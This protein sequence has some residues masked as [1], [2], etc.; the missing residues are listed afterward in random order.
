[1]EDQLVAVV[2]EDLDLLGQDLLVDEDA[3]GG[4]AR[5]AAQVLVRHAALG[6][7]LDHE[8]RSLEGGLDGVGE[9][10]AR[11]EDVEVAH[12]CVPPLAASAIYTHSCAGR[13]PEDDETCRSSRSLSSLSST[14]PAEVTRLQS[15]TLDNTL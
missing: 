6:G 13:R 4:E 9:L 12:D 3:D 8:A 7:H 5:G 15:L 14:A 10:A 11:V 1:M 2:P